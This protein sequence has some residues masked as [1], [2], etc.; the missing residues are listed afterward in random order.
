L[1]TVR[2][3]RGDAAGQRGQHEPGLATGVRRHARRLP[4]CF[5]ESRIRC[6]S[7]A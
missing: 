3:A 1:E 6:L 5:R 2:L 7:P 4:M